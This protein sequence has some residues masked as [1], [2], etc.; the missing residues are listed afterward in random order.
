MHNPE[1]VKSLFAKKGDRLIDET[2]FNIIC[3]L[4]REGEKTLKAIADHPSVN[5][6][7]ASVSSRLRK[8]EDNGIFVKYVPLTRIEK[9]GFAR[10]LILLIQTE[11][12]ANFDSIQTKLNAIEGVKSLYKLIGEYDLFVHLCCMGDQGLE[13]TLNE[14]NQI[15]G[16]ARVSKTMVQERLKENFHNLVEEKTSE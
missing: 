4:E 7:P 12:G 10:N 9:I 16:L 13:R 14:I 2:D 3:L 5:L 1:D 8:L 15:P 6:T 11:P